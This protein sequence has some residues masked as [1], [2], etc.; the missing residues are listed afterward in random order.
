MS[1]PPK[2]IP[3]LFKFYNEYVK[4]LY[5]AIQIENHLPVEVLFELNAAFDHLA[6]KWIF[7]EDESIVVA[8]AYSHL[9]RSCLDI[10]KLK[11]KMAIIQYN[12]LRKIDTSILDNGNFDSEMIK[13][14]QEMK[15]LAKEARFSEG[16]KQ[17]DNE[18]NVLAFE[19]WQPAYNL[20]VE[21][22]QRFY[23]HKHLDWA[24]KRDKYNKLL[25]NWKTFVISILA[26]WITSFLTK[27]FVVSIWDK[28]IYL[29]LKH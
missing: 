19:K 10:F 14:I 16:N 1:I 20:A 25:F 7:D 13:I 2:D 27:E 18:D 3:D 22:E 23:Q 9:K 21:F 4:I 24:K 29:F 12:E 5:S 15:N 8:K 11:V 6:R 28:V 26:T 17:Y